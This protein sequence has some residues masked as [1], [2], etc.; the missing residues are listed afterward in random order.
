MFIQTTKLSSMFTK[1][2]VFGIALISAMVMTGIVSAIPSNAQTVRTQTSIVDGALVTVDGNPDVYIVK[3]INGKKFRRLILNP[4]IFDSYGHLEW[5]NVITVSQSVMNSYTVSDLVREIY[6]DGSLVP[7]GNV[8]KL[9]PQGDTGIKRLLRITQSEFESRFDRDSIYNI[10]HLEAGPTFYS[11]GSDITSVGLDSVAIVPAPVLPP[12]SLPSNIGI[13]DDNDNTAPVQTPSTPTGT[14]EGIIE[15]S[16]ETADLASSLTQGDMD[17]VLAVDVEAEDSDIILRRIDVGF[18]GT[19]IG[20]KVGIGDCT[21]NI[22]DSIIDNDSEPTSSEECEDKEYRPWKTFDKAQLIVDGDVVATKSSL[23]STDFPLVDGTGVRGG[24]PYNLYA[25]TAP[26]YRLRFSGL[27]EMILE[28]DE[29]RVEVALRTFDSL[30]DNRLNQ[31]W[32]VAFITNGIRGTDEAGLNQFAGDGTMSRDYGTYVYDNTTGNNPGIDTDGTARTFD[33]VM[34]EPGLSASTSDMEVD[35]IARVSDTSDT[36]DIVLAHFRVSNT[37]DGPAA[38]LRDAELEIVSTDASNDDKYLNATQIGELVSRAK[39]YEGSRHLETVDVDSGDIIDFEDI[40]LEFDP[41]EEKTLTLKIDINE[42]DE[43]YVEGISIKGKLISFT[44]DY[45]QDEDTASWETSVDG[46][47]VVLYATSPIVTSSGVPTFV[48]YSSQTNEGVG[49]FNIRVQAVGGDVYV[50]SKCDDQMTESTSTVGNDPV[51]DVDHIGFEFMI[52]DGVTGDNDPKRWY[53]NDE[54]ECDV[55]DASNAT[56]VDSSVVTGNAD[57]EV[58]RINEG[59]TATFTITMSVTSSTA[60]SSNR[61]VRVS[62]DK[63]WWKGDNDADTDVLSGLDVSDLEIRS[64]YARLSKH[65][66]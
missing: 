50:G 16:L 23:D 8:Y 57:N 26:Y 28:D 30:K 31:E 53:I 55:T 52:E 49:T 25:D 66:G 24:S 12:S 61:N 56:V 2:I 21:V 32:G 38:I 59:E 7:P 40:D 27:E 43:D 39:L 58:Y 20:K 11:L 36:S 64:G 17:S 14:D 37:E 47:P 44:Y 48:A 9:Y 42:L 63:L 51:E 4:T 33:I 54:G 35:K 19:K 34:E 65:P 60:A 1:T 45:G 6:P 18:V 13:G 15:V 41:D 62:L 29:V 3:L 46:T 10:N 5:E 22:G